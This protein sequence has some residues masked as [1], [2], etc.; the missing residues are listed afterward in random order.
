M[1]GHQAIT[2]G[3][4]SGG[5]SGSAGGSAGCSLCQAA[6]ARAPQLL[7][8]RC[9]QC[10]HIALAGCCA[11]GERE[12]GIALQLVQ[13]RGG[14]KAWKDGRRGRGVGSGATDGAA[15][16]PGAAA[17]ARVHIRW[18]WRQQ[19]DACE[20]ICASNVVRGAPRH[21]SPL[22]CHTAEGTLTVLASSRLIATIVVFRC[23]E[24]RCKARAQ[25]PLA[26][27]VPSAAPTQAAVVLGVLPQSNRLQTSQAAARTTRPPSGGGILPVSHITVRCQ[28]CRT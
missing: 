6:A 19:R 23:A 21:F 15:P 1:G 27:G 20:T 24:E 25:S 26:A 22:S 16:A 12:Y 17:A 11:S 8:C 4:S 13:Q 14:I 2:G 28:R 9:N 3:G 18:M 10:F 7:L 5:G